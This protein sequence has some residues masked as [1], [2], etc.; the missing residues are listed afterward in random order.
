[1]GQLNNASHLESK[2]PVMLKEALNA[3]VVL[4]NVTNTKE[5]FDWIN[6]TFYSIRIRRNP[7]HYGVSKSK[8]IPMDVMIEMYLR[9][10]LENVIL[11]LN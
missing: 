8:D 1:M 10:K 6:H 7:G 4:G 2:L 9:E 5:S 11:E 3:E